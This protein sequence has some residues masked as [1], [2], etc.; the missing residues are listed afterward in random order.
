MRSALTRAGRRNSDY[1][2]R[3]DVKCA[4]RMRRRTFRGE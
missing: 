2:H 1:P 3:V 4:A